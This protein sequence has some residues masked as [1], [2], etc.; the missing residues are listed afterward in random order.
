MLR[1]SCVVTLLCLGVDARGLQYTL[2]ATIAPS[3]GKQGCTWPGAV[4]YDPLATYDDGSCYCAQLAMSWYLNGT[5][6]IMSTPYVR[7]VDPG[8]TAAVL[9]DS[10]SI[11]FYGGNQTKTTTFVDTCTRTVTIDNTTTPST[12]VIKALKLRGTRN[13]PSTSWGAFV[14][15]DYV[16]RSW[17]NTSAVNSAVD[18]VGKYQK[19]CTVALTLDTTA[20]ASNTLTVTAFPVNA[21]VTMPDK[22][23]CVGY[24]TV[25]VTVNDSSCAVYSDTVVVD[26]K[27]PTLPVVQLQ[28]DVEVMWNSVGC[29]QMH[30]LSTM[31]ECLRSCL[32]AS[33]CVCAR[34]ADLV[35]SQFLTVC[36]LVNGSCRTGFVPNPSASTPSSWVFIDASSASTISSK[37]ILSIESSPVAVS[38]LGLGSG[39]TVVVASLFGL[40][41]CVL[42]FV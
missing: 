28:A 3:V 20:G 38:Y 18:T 24:Y 7:D 31:N 39:T 42:A 36:R 15:A 12:E 4:A 30:P 5:A 26:V 2:N 19:L 8:M 40:P 35:I 29:V 25:G 23:Q 33:V 13:R 27:C 37:W 34:G 6:S 22:R 1:F 16:E 17:R 9:T 32:C 21:S 10:K 14:T 11:T 41:V